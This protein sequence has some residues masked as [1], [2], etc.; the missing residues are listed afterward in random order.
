MENRTTIPWAP[1][2]LL[3]ETGNCKTPHIEYLTRQI[4]FRVEQER[5]ADENSPADRERLDEYRQDARLVCTTKG[6]I[7]AGKY[8]Q[9]A[10]NRASFKQTH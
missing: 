5:W 10:A 1:A 3:H 2:A 9:E 8:A 7:P 4:A 6:Y